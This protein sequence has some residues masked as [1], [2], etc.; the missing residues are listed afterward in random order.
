MFIPRPAVFASGYV[1]SLT[2][3]RIPVPV[4]REGS[5]EWDRR[6]RERFKTCTFL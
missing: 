6:S 2:L 5:T 1:E 3:S 4:V